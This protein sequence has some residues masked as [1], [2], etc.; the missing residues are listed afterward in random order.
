MNYTIATTHLFPW[1]SRIKGLR[2]AVW[3]K[4]KRCCTGVQVTR[5]S[6]WQG[7]TAGQW[8]VFRRCRPEQVPRADQL[9]PGHCRDLLANW[10]WW[11]RIFFFFTFR[12]T[13]AYL[14]I[15]TVP[16]DGRRMTNY[17]LRRTFSVVPLQN[18]VTLRT[19]FFTQCWLESQRKLWNSYSL[20]GYRV[21]KNVNISR[22]ASA[23]IETTES[24]ALTFIGL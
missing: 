10:D 19:N 6:T 8:T 18:C 12:P 16:C 24:S 7:C 14:N 4:K 2:V 9:D 13:H 20:K 3:K 5:P 1:R 23:A 17:T 15:A 22:L 21:F 11:V